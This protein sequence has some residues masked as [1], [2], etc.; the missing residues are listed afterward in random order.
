MLPQDDA[1]G[2]RDACENELAIA[3]QVLSFLG[4]DD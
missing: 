3:N 2:S 4:K 1:V